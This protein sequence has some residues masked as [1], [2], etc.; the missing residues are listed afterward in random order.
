MTNKKLLW[1]LPLLV[2]LIIGTIYIVRQQR[3]MPYQHDEGQ[4]FGTFYHITYQN[5]SSIQTD[6]LAELQKV[7]N[8][9]SM[10]NKESIIS[11]INLVEE[12]SYRKELHELIR[13]HY[14]YTGSK[15]ARTMLDD[16]NR[17]VEDF[18]QVVPIEYK[19]VLQEEQ[20][21]K[22]QQK[23]ADMQRDY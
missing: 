2:F 17:Y 19:R 5:D 9:L 1:R 12:S 16:W 14:L 4:I 13:Q 7:D 21:K 3:S 11:H 23:I 6:I 18:I 8:A 20:V 15:L 10:F 22:L